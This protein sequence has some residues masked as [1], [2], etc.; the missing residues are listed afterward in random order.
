MHSD[1]LDF[2]LRTFLFYISSS[3]EKKCLSHFIS[4]VWRE[5]KKKK[6]F[7]KLHLCVEN[8]TKSDREVYLQRSWY[9]F[10]LPSQIISQPP[11]QD[12][13]RVL[14]AGFH[15]HDEQ[16]NI[17]VEIRTFSDVSLW[18]RLNLWVNIK[19]QGSY[20]LLCSSFCSNVCDSTLLC[21][22]FWFFFSF[23]ASSNIWLSIKYRHEWG[24]VNR[25]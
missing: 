15:Q 5:G 22:S 11:F 23:Y 24:E 17:A 18:C 20:N 14:R 9:S 12:D 1:G 25:V 16:G 19:K 6:T 4:S 8:D 2:C 21:S 13:L 10:S 7:C 3:G